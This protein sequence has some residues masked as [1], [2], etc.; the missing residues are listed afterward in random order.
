MDEGRTDQ[1]VFFA[2]VLLFL[3][4]ASMAQL[5]L[6]QR[7]KRRQRRKRFP[8][9]L[10]AG[11]PG[12]AFPRPHTNSARNSTFLDSAAGLNCSVGAAR[13]IVGA[14]RKRH[15]QRDWTNNVDVEWSTIAKKLPVFWYGHCIT[16]RMVNPVGGYC[17]PTSMT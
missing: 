3:N 13:A 11:L 5:P 10:V 6:I 4:G 17:R 7:K 14:G 8:L 12:L 9:R 16:R 2:F 1:L 15:K